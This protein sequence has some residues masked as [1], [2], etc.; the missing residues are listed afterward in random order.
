MQLFVGVKAVVHYEGKILLLRESTAYLDGAEAGKW[1][2]PGGRIES[3][4]TLDEGLAREVHEECGLTVTR[5]KLLGAFDGFPVIRGETCHVV[6][7]YF[8]SQAK[9]DAVKLSS[10]HDQYDWVD[11]KDPGVKELMGDI[12]EMLEAAHEYL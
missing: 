1:D 4:E 11:P 2:V 6:R 3:D 12:A 10:D 8:L 5:Q 9:T 7:L